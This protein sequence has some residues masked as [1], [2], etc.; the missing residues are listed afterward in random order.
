MP[1]VIMTHTATEGAHA[2]EAIDNC[3][4][5]PAAAC[6]SGSLPVGSVDG[7]EQVNADHN[8]A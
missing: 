1:L 4:G 3:R 5:R 6:G 7:C 2:R 8:E